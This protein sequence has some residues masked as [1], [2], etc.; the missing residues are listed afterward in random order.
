MKIAVIGGGD[1][2]LVFK[3]LNNL[4]FERTFAFSI[5]RKSKFNEYARRVGFNVIIVNKK[6]VNWE[7][8]LQK[9]I[10][11][12]NPDILLNFGFEEKLEKFEV[13]D[14]KDIENFII[15]EFKNK[16]VFFGDNFSNFLDIAMLI[17][18]Q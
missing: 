6:F 5:D 13:F 12:F 4:K 18:K 7:D 8:E 9:A 10:I 1:S 17:K 15:V 16:V 14:V 3:L 2:D 11:D